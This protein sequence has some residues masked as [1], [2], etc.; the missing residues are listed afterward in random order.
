[1]SPS[2]V[3]KRTGIPVFTAN[4]SGMG[5]GIQSVVIPIGNNFPETK[6]AAINALKTNFRLQIRLISIISSKDDSTIVPA[7][8]LNAYR[9]LRNKPSNFVNY[10]ILY[11]KN[12]IKTILSYCAHVNA[13]LLIVNAETETN[14]GWLKTPISEMLPVNWR[15]QILAV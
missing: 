2:L 4:T 1:V 11:G 14:T 13:D 8:L 12:R 10:E 3:A 15:T 7:S 6:L 9:I 5:A